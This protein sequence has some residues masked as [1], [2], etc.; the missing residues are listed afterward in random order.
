VYLHNEVVRA[1]RLPDSEES[2]L[3]ELK[4]L[5]DTVRSFLTLVMDAHTWE[6]AT[7]C[8]V[9]ASSI[10]YTPFVADSVLSPV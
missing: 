5:D 8:G 9:V 2:K 7:Y 6:E 4:I 3:R 1:A 10:R